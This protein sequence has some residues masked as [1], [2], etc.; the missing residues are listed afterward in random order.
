MR[1]CSLGS[2]SGGNATLIEAIQ[3]STSTRVRGEA[4]FSVRELVKR[5]ERAGCAPDDVDDLVDPASWFDALRKGAHALDSWHRL[6]GVGERP[7]GHLREHL[8]ERVR[9]T[10]R[11][12][13]GT[14]HATLLDPDGRPA[15]LRRTN[16]F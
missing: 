14:I 2:G 6:D 5:L 15:H 1:F 9:G 7:P 8:F 3:G 12:G 16:A 10:R 13:R 4:G 11:W